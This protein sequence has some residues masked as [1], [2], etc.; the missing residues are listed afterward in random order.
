MRITDYMERLGF[1]PMFKPKMNNDSSEFFHSSF[2]NLGR[3][4]G[5]LVFSLITLI[6]GPIYQYCSNG[7]RGR[8][9]SFENP[10]PSFMRALGRP[11]SKPNGFR[12]RV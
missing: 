8:P 5:Y 4:L 11:H 2:E 12:A 1:S 6:R 7:F 3:P 10:S 9:S